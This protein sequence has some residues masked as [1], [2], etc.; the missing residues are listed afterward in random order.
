[1]SR[2]PKMSGASIEEVEKKPNQAKTLIKLAMACDVFHTPDGRGFADIPINGHRETWSIRSKGFRR[3]LA[4]RF[5]E[6][7]AGAPNNEATQAALDVIEAMAQFKG[8]E[9]EVHVRTAEYAGRIYIDLADEGWRAIEID[10]AGWRIVEQPPVRFRRPVGMMPLP[11]P[12]PGGSLADLRRFANVASDDDFVLLVAWLLAALRPRG[13]YP[14]LI[15]TGEHGSAKSSLARLVRALVDPNTASLRSPPRDEHDLVIAAKNG[16]VIAIDNVSSLPPWL[17]DALCR[18]ATGGGFSTRKLYSDDEEMLFC[19][20]R[21]S[22]LN[23]IEDF[24]TRPD[25]ADRTILLHLEAIS[26]TKR[27]EE[28]DF[29][30]DF[31]VV[32]PTLLGVLCDGLTRGLAA[33]P[34]TRL[35]RLPRMADF[36]KWATACEG[37]FWPT[38]TFMAAYEHNRAEANET[39]IEADTVAIAVRVLVLASG[40]WT[41]TA[42]QLLT[43]LSE[44]AGE[45]ATR[46]KFWPTT[47]RALSGRLR[48][49]APNLRR[50]GVHILFEREG[51]GRSRTITIAA[52]PDKGVAQPSASSALSVGTGE[53]KHGSGLDA[54]ALR[55]QTERADANTIREAGVVRSTVRCDCPENNGVDDADDADAKIPTFSGR[56]GS[57][58][59]EWEAPL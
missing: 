7:T 5:F 17:S 57:A 44:K 21:P 23:G 29:W 12:V 54:D 59:H 39:I 27:Q 9:R 48:R 58:P 47:P 35:S 30:A 41:G 43:A 53:P 1:M 6:A 4:S 24:V 20:Q 51:H 37:A 42:T 11:I 13:P 32:G 31:E 38:G 40:K 10:A 45:A 56:D 22:I 16:H 46:A 36:A 50:C 19:A 2:D 14:V 25:L 33:L 15:L 3:W 18:L 55:T 28:A 26:E 49:A 34:K 52:G 8:A